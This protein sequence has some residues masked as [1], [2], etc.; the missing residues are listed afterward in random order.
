MSWCLWEAM[1]LCSRLGHLFTATVR[2]REELGPRAT[3]W[4]GLCIISVARSG[5]GPWRMQ[6]REGEEGDMP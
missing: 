4:S 3:L 5:V 1:G 6:Q 2:L